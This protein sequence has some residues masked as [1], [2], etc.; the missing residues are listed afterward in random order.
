[1]EWFPQIERTVCRDH[2]FDGGVGGGSYDVV[3]T[4]SQHQ[5]DEEAVEE[6]VELWIEM[7]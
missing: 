7:D 6:K 2:C 5:G 4:D 1:M 3:V